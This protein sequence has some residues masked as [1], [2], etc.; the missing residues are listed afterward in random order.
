VWAIAHVRV[1]KSAAE[2]RPNLVL[3]LAPTAERGRREVC[4]SGWPT[5]ARRR[6]SQDGHEWLA[7]CQL[8]ALA[9]MGR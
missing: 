8:G 2:H 6:E 7:V 3:A 5:D 9:V 1:P 4:R